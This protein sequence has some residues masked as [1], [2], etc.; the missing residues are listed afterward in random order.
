MANYYGVQCGVCG[1]V[2]NLDCTFEQAGII[3]RYMLARNYDRRSVPL[4]HEALPF[5]NAGDREMLISGVCPAC[6]DNM[7][8]GDDEEEENVSGC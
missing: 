8:G 4:I 3:D 2:H 7:F 6:W 1:K 5:L